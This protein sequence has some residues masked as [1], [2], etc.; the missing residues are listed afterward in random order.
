MTQARGAGWSCRS[1]TRHPES[2]AFGA[3]EIPEVARTMT[4]G[5]RTGNAV[6]GEAGKA[7]ARTLGIKTTEKAIREWLNADT[8]TAVLMQNVKGSLLP[9]DANP[10]V[11]FDSNTLVGNTVA[12]S[13]AGFAVA[14]YPNDGVGFGFLRNSIVVGNA[15]TNGS[16]LGGRCELAQAVVGV[17]AKAPQQNDQARTPPDLIQVN[18]DPHFAGDTTN[19]QM[20]C[21]RKALGA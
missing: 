20:C 8:R 16:Q 6:L 19:N 18:K 13:G 21:L 12:A 3:A 15:M 17:D 4:E 11:W 9:G 14:C 5:L 2:Y 1:F 7:A 10:G